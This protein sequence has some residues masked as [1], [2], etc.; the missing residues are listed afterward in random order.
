MI[1]AEVKEEIKNYQDQ[2]NNYQLEE[3]I[4]EKLNEFFD[5]EP[6]ISKDD[7]KR[8][9]RLFITLVLFREEDKENK[10]KNNHKN[11]INYLKAQ[12]LWDKIIFDDE[13]FIENLNELKLFNLQINQILS[14]YN[15]LTDNKEENFFEEIQNYIDN[16]ANI[17]M[18]VNAP[19][20]PIDINN[21]ERHSIS[22][23]SNNESNNNSDE[24]EDNKYDQDDE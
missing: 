16:K 20:P 23:N 3:E 22:N 4:I 11:L 17:N 18:D 13:N 1:F 19:Q 2:N 10:I 7:F 12:D 24:E 21:E 5:K 15:Y 14:L 6:L 9:I 8:A